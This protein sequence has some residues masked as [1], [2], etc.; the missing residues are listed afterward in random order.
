MKHTMAL[1]ASGCRRT[2]RQLRFCPG[3]KVPSRKNVLKVGDT[4]P[5]FT[6]PQRRVEN[7]EAHDYRGKKMSFSAVLCWLH[8]RLNETTSGRS[9]LNRLR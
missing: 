7:R 5:E 3:E 9:R 1:R 8:R 4:A 2:W 6:P